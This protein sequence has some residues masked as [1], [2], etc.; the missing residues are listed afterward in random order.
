MSINLFQPGQYRVV[1]IIARLN[2]GGPAQAVMDLCSGLAADHPTLVIAGSVSDGEADASE[3][4]RA[5]GIDVLTLPELGRTIRIGH[6]LAAFTKLLRLL[7]HIRPQVV[8]THT[9][10]AGTLGRLAA[11][12]AGVPTV[13]HTFHGHVF[14]NYFSQPTTQFVIRI[15]RALARLTDCIIAISETQ[16]HDLGEVNKGTQSFI[17]RVERS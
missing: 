12:A 10:K 14:R 1:H 16:R 17:G 5:R 9:A 13:I 15:E 6:D 8:H 4:A 7:R 3:Y 2:I 11:R